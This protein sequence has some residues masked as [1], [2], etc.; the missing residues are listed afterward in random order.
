MLS[1][2]ELARLVGK[3]RV[4]QMEYMRT[5][6][7]T[8]GLDATRLEKEVDDAIRNVVDPIQRGLFDENEC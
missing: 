6:S 5:K 7:L 4:A 8:A 2:V 1:V 3:M